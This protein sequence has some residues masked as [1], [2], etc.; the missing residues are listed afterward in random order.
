MLDE[1]ESDSPHSD[2]LTES[3]NEQPGISKKQEDYGILGNFL[4]G[5]DQ[6]QQ[7]IYGLDETEENEPEEKKPIEN[8]LDFEE[9][10][11]LDQLGNLELSELDDIV[12][13]ADNIATKLAQKTS[14]KL[15]KLGNR[16]KKQY[17]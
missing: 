12:S 4:Q 2:G 14:N 5:L 10:D 1:D 3:A 13:F 17:D 15:K 11:E 7:L 9:N 16:G 6:H 8:E